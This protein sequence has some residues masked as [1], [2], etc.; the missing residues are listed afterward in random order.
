MK[1][2]EM[3]NK[4]TSLLST[5]VELESMKLENGTILE[6]ENF[7]S[8]ENVFIV[9]E[10]EK[11]ALPIGDYQLE[12]GNTLIVSEE[13]IIDDIKSEMAEEKEEVTEELDSLVRKMATKS[14]QKVKAKLSNQ[15][16]WGFEKWVKFLHI[17]QKEEVTEELD[18]QVATGSEPRDLEAE[19]DT[20]DVVEKPKSKSKKDLSD[21]TEV[22]EEENLEEEEKDEMNKI[23]EEVVAAMTPIIDEMKQELAYVKEELGKMKDEELAKQEVQEKLSTEPAT[24]AIKHNPETKDDARLNLLSKNKKANSTMD[25]VLQRMSNFNK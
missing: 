8:G 11:V 2:T 5:K 18:S 17:H 22:Q 20:E 16:R 3:L 9:T 4:I 15:I 12:D 25:R 24:K 10:D 23:V 13:G 7:T 21:E 19:K 6:A 1:P 14:L